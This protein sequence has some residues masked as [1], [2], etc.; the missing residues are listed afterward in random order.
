MSKIQTLG[1]LLLSWDYP[2]PEVL[3]ARESLDPYVIMDEDMNDLDLGDLDL[4]GLEEAY[5]HKA[6]HAFLGKKI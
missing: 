6:L 5:R 2:P 3:H 4:L 1:T